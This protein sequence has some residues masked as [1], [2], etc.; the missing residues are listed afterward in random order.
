MPANLADKC[1]IDGSGADLSTVN[2]DESTTAT[3]ADRRLRVVALIALAW[4]VGYLTWRVGWTGRGAQPALYVVLLVAEIVGWINLGLFTFLAWRIPGH[5]PSTGDARRRDAERTYRV[6]VVVPTYDESTDVLR[7][8]LL[9]CRALRHPHTTWLL[10]D[11]RR[12]EMAELARELGARYLTRPDNAHAKAGNINHALPHLEGDLVAVLDADHVPLPHFLDA[13]VGYFDDDEV[14]LAQAP[15]E[16]Y[17]LDSIQHIAED[18]HEQ[19]LFFRIICPGKDRHNGV[20]WCGSGTVLRRAPLLEIGGVQTATIAE[21]FHTTIVLHSRGWKTRYHDETLLLGLAPH[22]LGSFLLQRSR[23]ARGNLRVFLTR[24][25]PLWAPRLTPQQ[26]LSY[27][28]SLSHYFGGP[29]RLALLGVLCATLLTGQLPLRGAPILFAVLWAPWVVLSLLSTRLLGRGISGPVAATK[30]GWMTM[31]AYTCATLSLLVP[32]A[33]RFRVTPKTGTDAGGLRVLANLRLLTAA[34]V[35]LTVAAAARLGDVLGVVSL[36]PMPVFARIGTLVIAAVE[37]A[38]IGS[39][40]A[41]LV[42]R[43]QRRQTFRF[44]VDVTARVGD[45]VLRVADL[46]HHGAGL[47]VH[48]TLPPGATIDLT[49]RLPG[50]D[51]ELHRLALRAVVRSARAL[52]D[53]SGWRLGVEF[54]D[55]APTQV[56]QILEYCHVLR[57]AATTAAGRGAPAGRAE[58]GA[59]A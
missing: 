29:Q 44:A 26:R 46:N 39:L 45:Q 24:Q 21:D 5:A 1:S 11:G 17:N 40:L 36:P 28:A 6:D 30:H 38:I 57:P 35:A 13:L 22:D 52:D 9:G 41:S 25:N 16:F 47:V 51:G 19:S 53:A 8:T 4:G 56:D 14:V 58:V 10:D 42:E 48:D 15:H 59:A 27:F 54:V 32:A 20:F 37:L 12:P 55:P 3:R 33:G 49:L 7:A 43:R 2:P 23:W 18:R 50:L 31:G 34:T